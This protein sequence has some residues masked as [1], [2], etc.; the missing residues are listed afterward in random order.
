[1]LEPFTTITTLHIA[2]LQTITH[3]RSGRVLWV[4]EEFVDIRPLL[5]CCE[6][7]MTMTT[8]VTDH[9]PV[10]SMPSNIQTCGNMLITC[11]RSDI[12]NITANKIA[13]FLQLGSQSSWGL[14]SNIRFNIC[15]WRKRFNSLQVTSLNANCRPP[16]A[17]NC[18]MPSK[19]FTCKLI[20]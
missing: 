2:S 12:H 7:T 16:S 9:L 14:P 5:S 15:M 18:D 11:W 13:V 3:H 10:I 1:M 20:G 19:L 17:G 8:M 4:S 6:I